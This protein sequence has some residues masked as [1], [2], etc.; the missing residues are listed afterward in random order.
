[1]GKRRF[2]VKSLSQ[3]ISLVL[4]LGLVY[5]VY[6]PVLD[7]AFVNW[8]DDVYVTENPLVRDVSP[9]GLKRIATSYVSGNYH[10]LTIASYAAEHRL[11]GL[12]ARSF[13][14]VNLLL[15]LSLCLLVFRFLRVL[16]LPPAG[17]FAGALLWALHPQRVEVVA[18]V[19]GR[20]DLLCT[21]FYLASCL[22]YLAY[23]EKRRLPPFLFSLVL[24]LL[25]LFS[26]ATAVTLPAALLLIDYLKGAEGDSTNGR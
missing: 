10:P 21:F 1:M 4:L 18:W 23:L 25:A 26:K 2:S 20:K 14:L 22:A 6:A 12:S 3:S 16:G 13:H 11:F 17:A 19:S 9:S 15:H 8:D 24:F 5:I 7:N